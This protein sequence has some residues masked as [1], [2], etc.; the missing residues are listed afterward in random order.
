MDNSPVSKPNTIKVAH[1]SSK[2]QRS[3]SRQSNKNTERPA[4][5]QR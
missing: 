4:V 5:N 2:K 1:V 3:K